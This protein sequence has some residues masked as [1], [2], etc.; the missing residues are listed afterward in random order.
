MKSIDLLCLPQAA[1]SNDLL[2]GGP[3]DM[4]VLPLPRFEKHE[5]ETV[6]LPQL[7]CIEQAVLLVHCALTELGTARDELRSWQMAPFF[8]A[9]RAQHKSSF[10]IQVRTLEPINSQ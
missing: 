2:T 10:M 5:C 4:D 7:T 1:G 9:V 8:E 3:G 6:D